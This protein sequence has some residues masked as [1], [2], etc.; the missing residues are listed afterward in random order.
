MLMKCSAVLR[1]SPK[2][3]IEVVLSSA[4]AVIVPGKRPL[5]PVL[6]HNSF[7]PCVVQGLSIKSWKKFWDRK[8]KLGYTSRIHFG[9]GGSLDD[10]CCLGTFL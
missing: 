9:G 6:C 10:Y 4:E 8:K 1:K 3:D 5:V 2:D 7:I